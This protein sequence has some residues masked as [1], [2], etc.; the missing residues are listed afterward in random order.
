MSLTYH[1]HPLASFCHKPL[2]ALYENDTPFDTVLVDLGDESSGADFKEL[3]PVG[4][5]PVLRDTARDRIVPES[6]IIIEYLDRYYPGKIQFVPTDAEEAWRTRL[7]DRFYDLYVQ[8]PMQKIVVDRIRPA[9]QHDAFGVEQARATL[10]TA[11]GMIERDMASRTWAMGDAFTMA[12]CA[13]APAL[14]Y[15]EKV[16][17]FTGTH[18][19]MAAYFD[20]LLN[21]P[22][23]AR[24]LT[25]AEP[26]FKFFPT[27]NLN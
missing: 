24:V 20:R 4:K 12:D 14:F 10:R 17:P 25:E 7:A 13:A 23:F 18:R 22:S 6:T 19:H 11:Y 9:G 27:Q 1:F 26:Y 8:E 16:E 21:R 5:M 3:W 2:I 15:A